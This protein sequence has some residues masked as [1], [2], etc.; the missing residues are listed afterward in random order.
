MRKG[1]PQSVILALV[2]FVVFVLAMSA[3]RISWYG[4]QPAQLVPSWIIPG[5]IAYGLVRRHRL[6]WQW[7]RLLG[8][9]VAVV[10][11]I[12]GV[13]AIVRFGV[14]ERWFV[15][16]ALAIPPFVIGIALGRPSAREW[17]LLTCPACGT[18]RPRPADFLFQKAQ[19]RACQ[20][21]W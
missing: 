1:I 15:L 4:A 14:T 12:A 9:F 21:V 7:V 19:C 20:N 16:L 11:T 2:S 13:A 5:L 3:I 18:E 6:A 10:E 17:F 8:L